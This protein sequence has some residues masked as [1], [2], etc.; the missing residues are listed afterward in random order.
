MRAVPGATVANS[1]RKR[2]IALFQLQHL[3]LSWSDRKLLS[4]RWRAVSFGNCEQHGFDSSAVGL[5]DSS[6]PTLGASVA[7]P[8]VNNVREIKFK[9]ASNNSLSGFFEE[10]NGSTTTTAEVEKATSII[11][12]GWIVLAAKGRQLIWFLLRILKLPSL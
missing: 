11:A 3:K 7:I 6:P 4:A 2:A 10:I 9:A 5:T 12:K 1:D 8:G